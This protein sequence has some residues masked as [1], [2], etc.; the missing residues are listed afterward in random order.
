[1]NLRQIQNVVNVV[2]ESHGAAIVKLGKEMLSLHPADMPGGG[3]T[4]VETIINHVRRRAEEWRLWES[5]R[6][7]LIAQMVKG[8]GAVETAETDAEWNAKINEFTGE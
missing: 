2:A 6:C 8:G 3:R 7:C 4:E 1:M 5:R